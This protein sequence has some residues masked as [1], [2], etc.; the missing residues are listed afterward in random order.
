MIC[1]SVLCGSDGAAARRLFTV[2]SY[3][4]RSPF[5]RV[6]GP[7]YRRLFVQKLRNRQG[8]RRLAGGPGRLHPCPFEPIFTHNTVKRGV[9]LQGIHRH[10]VFSAA[11]RIRLR[12]CM[13]CEQTGYVR[14]RLKGRREGRDRSDPFRGIRR[15][16]RRPARTRGC[17]RADSAA[18][19]R[20]RSEWRSG[21]R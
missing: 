21:S 8:M 14:C 15:S 4:R 20:W 5:S 6:T 11:V 7:D 10:R 1:P 2:S 17:R 18:F 13:R 12:C 16:V 9:L 3:R 19:R